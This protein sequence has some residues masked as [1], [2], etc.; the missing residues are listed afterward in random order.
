M[1]KQF[2]GSRRIATVED[3]QNNPYNV[4]NKRGQAK[5][6]TRGFKTDETTENL[7]K[8]GETRVSNSQG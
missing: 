4:E 1:K 6:R 5:L 8:I 7:M 3:R 2:I